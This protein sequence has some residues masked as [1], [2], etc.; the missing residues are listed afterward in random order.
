MQLS[1]LLA[2]TDL[3]LSKE[4]VLAVVRHDSSWLHGNLLMMTPKDT[5]NLVA[6]Q[7]RLAF[8]HSIHEF[9]FSCPQA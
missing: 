6:L 9:L 2:K 3:E 5:E 4:E 1:F 8:T 7:K